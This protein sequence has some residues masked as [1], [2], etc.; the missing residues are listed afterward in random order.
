MNTASYTFNLSN[1]MAGN[2]EVAP[3]QGLDMMG[4]GRRKKTRGK[5]SKRKRKKTTKA[6][7]MPNFSFFSKP[8]K[9]PRAPTPPTPA[10]P[11]PDFEFISP[12]GPEA[13][14]PGSKG[15]SMKMKDVSEPEEI[16]TQRFIKPTFSEGQNN[17][18][19]G[20]LKVLG[21][22]EAA[23]A[24]QV[25]TAYRKLSLKGKYRH[26]DKGGS[27]AEFKKI[28]EA[29]ETL[30]RSI[31]A[32]TKK[33]RRSR[34][35]TKVK[36]SPKQMR[37]FSENNKE[38]RGLLKSFKRRSSGKSRPS[39][40]VTGEKQDV[41]LE[42]TKGNSNKFWSAELSKKKDMIFTSW[43]KIGTSTSKHKT[44][45][46]GRSTPYKNI[47]TFNKLVQSKLKKGYVRGGTDT[48][49]NATL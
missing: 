15:V 36:A 44:Q 5:R 7:M 14:G 21:L 22:D 13:T 29:N 46:L 45:H 26:P 9:S 24:A 11:S 6:G 18:N 43:G 33:Q 40:M 8:V 16:P 12:D 30:M 10:E 1:D 41:Y 48:R 47:Q 25:K 17:K 35:R 49:P 42:Y 23:T 3:R 39:K 2:P 19:R 27:A 37:E 34:G 38:I 28:N 32:K 20:A 4:A 31:G